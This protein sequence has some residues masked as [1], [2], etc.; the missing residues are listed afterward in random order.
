[1]RAYEFITEA[2]D[3]YIEDEAVTRGDDSLVSTLETLRNRANDTH[4]VPM[5]RVDSLIN[6][7]RN[8]PGS[9]MFTVENLLDAY[10]TNDAVKNVIKDIKDNKD[11][12]KYVYLATFADS[13]DSEDEAIASANVKSPDKTVGSMA[14]RAL[15]KK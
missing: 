2:L 11:G 5:I 6:I 13:P 15:T 12:V 7:I 3:D 9:E 4:D 10:K 8:L 14:K 1:M